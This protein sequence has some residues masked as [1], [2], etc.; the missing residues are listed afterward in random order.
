MIH[1]VAL[2]QLLLNER[3]PTCRSCGILHAQQPVQPS[4]SQ[5]T[6]QPFQIRRGIDVEETLKRYREARNQVLTRAEEAMA[7]KKAEKMS[8]GVDQE[9]EGS[10][11]AFEKAW[12]QL[13][14]DM[15]KA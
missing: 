11:T 1:E 12:K 8:N 6:R 2:T 10:E 14:A 9:R 4:S 3:P 13:R 7:K 15:E 5:Q